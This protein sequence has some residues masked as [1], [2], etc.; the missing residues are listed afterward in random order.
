MKKFFN[1]AGKTRRE[2]DYYEDEVFLEEEYYEEDEYYPE[3][4]EYA[5]EAYYAE[6]EE[7]VEK[8]YYPENEEYAGETYYAE[9]EAG[10]EEAYYPENEE[11]TGEAYY[12][13]N[14][15]YVGAEYYPENEEYTGEAYY[16]ENEE[17][18]EEAYYPENEEYAGEAYYTENEEVVE[19]EYYP[20]NEE[21]AE[22]TYYAE[23]TYY[24]E[25]P[26]CEQGNKQEYYEEEQYQKGIYTQ[27]PHRKFNFMFM[28]SIDRIVAVTGVVVLIIALITGG[29]YVSARMVD[30]QMEEFVKVGTQLEDIELI[31][32]KGLMAVEDAQLAKLEAAKLIEEEEK[33]KLPEYNEMEYSNL[34]SVELDMVSIQKDLK[35]K[36]TNKETDKLIPNVPFSVTATDPDGKVINWKD[37]DMDGIIYK[38][39]ITP[40]NYKISVD[41]LTDS[42]YKDYLLPAGTQSIEVKKDIAYEK[43]DVKNEIKSE[44]QVNVAKEDT[45]KKETVVESAL[46]DTTKWLESTVT[47]NTYIEIMKNTIPDPNTLAGANENSD[48]SETEEDVSGNDAEDDEEEDEEEIAAEDDT[49]SKLLDE[50]FR[51]VY[52]LEETTYREAVYADYYVES[53]FYLKGDSKYTGW[54]T[55]D[56]KVYFFDA[57]GKKV[58]GEQIIQGAKYTFASDGSLVTG[59]SVMGIDVSKWNGSIDWSAVKNSG[60]SYVII[61]CGYRGSSQGALIE[62][63]TYRTNIKG[64]I[65]AGLNVGVYFFTQAVD[66]VEA[67]EEA[68]MVLELVSGYR[69]SYPIFLD[70]EASGGRADSLD[71]ATRTAVCKAFCETIQGAGYTAGIYANKTWLTEKIDTGA[72][73]GYKIWLAQYAA[74]PTYTGKYDIWQYSESGRVSGISGDVDLNTSYL[75]Y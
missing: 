61:R 56:G 37:D 22:E 51:Q 45:K 12:A 11:Y 21:Y 18:A 19:E 1:R 55:I 74:T 46:E 20:E 5:G 35:I 17:Y 63:S 60:V 71:K 69:I 75:G 48:D 49:E 67:V 53:Q 64:A 27:N 7:Y 38:K 2:Q 31:G 28:G 8:E 59:T 9:N 16:G 4:G 10:A 62:D 34:A 50:N 65:D 23:D 13:E 29:I 68:S 58:T 57:T 42:K 41:A 24:T 47:D 32:E 39:G 52:V 15:E 72:L 14:E 66:E 3:D 6:N 73:G 30:K 54:Q 26:Y 44:S 43:V 33:E 36:F 40:G 25:E 70:V